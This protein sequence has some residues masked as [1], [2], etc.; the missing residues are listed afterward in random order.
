MTTKGEVVI[1]LLEELTLVWLHSVPVVVVLLGTRC[2]WLVL[3]I[4]NGL[5]CLSSMW[6]IV[7]LND[8]VSSFNSGKMDLKELADI[9]PVSG[10]LLQD[11]SLE[12]PQLLSA[13]KVHELEVL[14]WELQEDVL[15]P[16]S[17]WLACHIT[18]GREPMAD[19]CNSLKSFEYP[20]SLSP[21][22]AICKLKSE[23]SSARY[24]LRCL[25]LL[26][27]TGII[28]TLLTGSSWNWVCFLAFVM[29]LGGC[30]VSETR[31]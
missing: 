24:L 16:V 3:R 17:D 4:V 6:W 8:L 9:V 13:S 19:R 27:L 14:D 28:W 11:S 12:L 2:L 5:S 23:V 25:C 15:M 7:L 18:A 31:Y 30:T 10:L 1:L 22:I 29:L 26:S 21:I 20:L